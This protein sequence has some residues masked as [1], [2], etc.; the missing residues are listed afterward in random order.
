MEKLVYE[1]IYMHQFKFS[2]PVLNFDFPIIVI[3]GLKIFVAVSRSPRQS[4][5][6]S[7]QCTDI[8]EIFVLYKLHNDIFLWLNLQHFQCQTQKWSGFDVASKNSSNKLQLHGLIDHQLR[9]EAE[10]LLL[11]VLGLIDP[12]PNDFLHQVLRVCAMDT[13][14]VF[15]R[16]VRHLL[17]SQLPAPGA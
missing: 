5:V 12:G 11:P 3:E 13:V 10:A 15:H 17:R 2:I 1:F 6:Q 16:P 9:S 4:H 14:S 8:L 7:T